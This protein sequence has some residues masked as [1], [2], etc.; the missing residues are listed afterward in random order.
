MARDVRCAHGGANTPPGSGQVRPSL[1]LE[2]EH[3][4]GEPTVISARA[5]DL[6][7]EALPEIARVVKAGEVVGVR[8]PPSLCE[9]PGI[10][11]S[12]PEDP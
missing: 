10:L 3:E 4:Q 2:V 6:T 7:V 1:L 5:G 11:E 12:G 8:E 9:E